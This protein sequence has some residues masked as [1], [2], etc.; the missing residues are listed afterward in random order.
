MDRYDRTTLKHPKEKY[1]EA[2]LKHGGLLT[3]A[4]RWLK[5]KPQTV[6]Q[7]LKR[8]PTLV[9]VL[10]DAKQ[11]ALDD[12]E[13]ALI[14]AART[15]EP[16]A[17][18][19]YL[20]HQGRERGYV[21]QKKT[22]AVP[23]FRVEV[24]YTEDALGATRPVTTVTQLLPSGHVPA[25]VATSPP[26]SPTAPDPSAERQQIEVLEAEVSF[27]TGPVPDPLDPLA[28]APEAVADA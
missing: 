3:P 8:W 18:Q 17:V 14:R 11:A 26:R 2:L 10:Q 13:W 15:G 6:H 7:A 20:R 19:Y 24:T 21:D 1:A 23:T 25:G 5:V 9:D 28:Q 22:D 12:T 4:A 27:P 16:W